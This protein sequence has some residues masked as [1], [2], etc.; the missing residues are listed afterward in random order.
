MK[1]KDS[2][3]RGNVTEEQIRRW[4]KVPV[5]QRLQW[6][7]EANEFVRKALSPKTRA[8]MEKFRRGEI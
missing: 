7:E 2:W 8:I 5:E 4:L 1:T 3:K 6:L